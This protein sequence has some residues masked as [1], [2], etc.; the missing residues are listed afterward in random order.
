[1]VRFF[2]KLKASFI[3]RIYIMNGINVYVGNLFKISSR[4]ETFDLRCLPIKVREFF[5][6]T[7]DTS[8]HVHCY[9]Y[10]N[11]VYIELEIKKKKKKRKSNLPNG[12]ESTRIANFILFCTLRAIDVFTD[13]SIR[14]RSLHFI[15]LDGGYIEPVVYPPG[16]SIPLPRAA[17]AGSDPRSATACFAYVT[18]SILLGINRH[19][20]TS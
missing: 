16:I 11:T 6:Y 17:D 10:L 7:R 1:M 14:S 8:A 18:S 19:A 9:N 15:N 3:D 5:V 20:G 12:E 13:T 2:I 4:L